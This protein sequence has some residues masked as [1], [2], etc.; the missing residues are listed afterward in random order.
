MLIYIQVNFLIPKINKDNDQRNVCWRHCLTSMQVSKAL[1]LS[2]YQVD[3]WGA[4]SYL[5]CL[6]VHNIL[7]LEKFFLWGFIKDRVYRHHYQTFK[8]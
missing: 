6:L 1:R 2:T 8:D 4:P 7:R 5:R 3:R